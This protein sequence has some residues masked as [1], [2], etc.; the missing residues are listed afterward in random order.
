MLSIS[1]IFIIEEIQLEIV[2]VFSNRCVKAKHVSVHAHVYVFMYQYLHTQAHTHIVRFCR[3]R[4]SDLGTPNEPN[5]SQYKT[6]SHK[7]T[8]KCQ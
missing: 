1:N 3:G 2:L 7:I 5:S 8:N 6:H 4:C